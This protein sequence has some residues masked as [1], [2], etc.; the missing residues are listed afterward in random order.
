MKSYKQED[1]ID[2]KVLYIN[3]GVNKFNVHEGKINEFSPTGKCIKINHEW[4]LLDK[5]SFLEVFKDEE[6]PGLKFVVKN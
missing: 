5:I 4:Y 2:K 3:T 1:L 6:R